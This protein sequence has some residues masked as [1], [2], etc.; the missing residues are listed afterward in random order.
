MPSTT[1]NVANRAEHDTKRFAVH[2]AMSTERAT[3]IPAHARGLTHEDDDAIDG[4][5]RRASSRATIAIAAL[6]GALLASCGLNVT[7]YAS[8]R[9]VTN[10]AALG[11]SL[12]APKG[13][14]REAR[15]AACGGAS[16]FSLMCVGQHGGA[17][18][19]RLGSWRASAAAL[20]DA[21]HPATGPTRYCR[22]DTWLL[23]CLF[24]KANIND[25]ATDWRHVKEECDGE[26]ECDGV[27]KYWTSDL[28]HI[29]SSGNADGC[30]A[31]L[32]DGKGTDASS[33]YKEGSSGWRAYAAEAGG[34]GSCKV[35]NE[36][37]NI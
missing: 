15:D 32:S 35:V 27:N 8:S 9:G 37:G 4:G 12:A 14:S 24:Y 10:A 33:F 1:S 7:Q 21:Q 16:S 2:I 23:S 3:L 19:A 25:E 36:W 31:S 17:N 11:V 28:W 29:A 30:D 34:D 20:G 22:K 26:I 13:L 6:S 18:E 5:A